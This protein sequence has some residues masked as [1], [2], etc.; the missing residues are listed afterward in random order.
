[1]IALALAWSLAAADPAPLP[2]VLVLG[3]GT[4][5]VV[6]A[7]G[8]AVRVRVESVLSPPGVETDA[9][10]GTPAPTPA[11]DPTAPPAAPKE[12][13]AGGAKARLAA[14]LD[15]I[16]GRAEAGKFA[17]AGAMVTADDQAV[18]AALGGDYAAWEDDLADFNAIYRAAWEA[19]LREPRHFAPLWRMFARGLRV[20]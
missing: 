12:T 1:M 17:D 18:R 4:A 8:P 14:A 6:P 3:D 2:R 13:P 19:G 20:P 10:P 7:A 11:A 16:A 15:E 9:W 5:I